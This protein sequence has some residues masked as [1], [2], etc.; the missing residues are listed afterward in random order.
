MRASGFLLA[1]C[2]AIQAAAGTISYTGTLASSIDTS[3]QITVTLASA[4][5]L[6]L[7]T[8]GFGGGT[9]A[10]SAVIPAGGFDPFVGV[11]AGTGD[12]AVFIDGTSDVLSNYTANCPPAATVNIG[13]GDVCG[14]VTMTLSLAAGTYT[15]LLTDALYYPAAVSETNGLLGDGFIDWTPQDAQGPTGAFQTCNTV[16]AT[17]TCITPTANWALDITTPDTTGSGGS[18]SVPEPGGL[19]VCGTGL[20][21]LGSVSRRQRLTGFKNN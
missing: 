17:T 15:V 20:I 1:A 8:F 9:N 21:V 10:A 16:G 2:F 18:E 3:T 11:F 6:D 7:Q 12:S 13:G 14:D 5:T 19:W 4:G